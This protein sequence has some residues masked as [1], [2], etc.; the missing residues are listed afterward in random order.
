MYIDNKQT[1]YFHFKHNEIY[2]N[3]A[4][5]LALFAAVVEENSFS[6]AAKK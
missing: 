6:Q 2:M 5:E 3:G 4:S 1:N